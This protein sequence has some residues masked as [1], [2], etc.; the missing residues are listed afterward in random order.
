MGHSSAGDMAF[1]YDL[2]DPLLKF[3]KFMVARGLLKTDDIVRRHADA[4]NKGP[5]H[6]NHEIGSVMK[7]ADERINSMAS[8][9]LEEPLPAA[10]PPQ[11][12]QQV[13]KRDPAIPQPPP[14]LEP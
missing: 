11:E 10:E 8:K 4:P 2:D 5:F 14:N 1:R 12:V 9:V 6:R 3:G 7:A 13:V